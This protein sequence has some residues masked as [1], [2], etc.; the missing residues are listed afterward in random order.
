M[1]E[2]QHSASEIDKLTEYDKR[3]GH[4]SCDKVVQLFNA[5]LA[6][7]MEDQERYKYA[8]FESIINQL[9]ESDDP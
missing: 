4:L 7:K 5:L 9:G 2:G 1:L 3:D 6:K 8:D